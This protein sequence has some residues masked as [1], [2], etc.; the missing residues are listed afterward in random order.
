MDFTRVKDLTGLR[1]TR[2]TVLEFDPASTNVAYWLCVCDCGVRKSVFGGD[3]KRG[4]SR[5]CGCL[6]LE[7]VT[8]QSTCH[9]MTKHPAYG[10]WKQMRYRCQDPKNQGYPIYGGRGITVCTRWINFEYFWEDM[11]PSWKF[12]LSIDRINVNGNYELSN[13]KWSTA[14]EQA[15]NRRTNITINTPR[16]P[17]IIAEASR[18]FGIPFNTIRQRV[19]AGWADSFL[20]KG[21]IGIT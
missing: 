12:G 4:G 18:Q 14:K 13:C 9:G 17:M 11:G 2:W 15:A 3:I 7:I 19:K 1:F 16:G 6:A 21:G 20:L 10:T 8:Q 5:S